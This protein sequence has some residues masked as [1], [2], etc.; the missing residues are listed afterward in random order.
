M[1]RNRVTAYDYDNIELT[2]YS[3]IFIVSKVSNNKTLYGIINSDGE[4]I[5]PVEYEDIK[6]SDDYFVLKRKNNEFYLEKR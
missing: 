5:I 6:I 4:E 3:N 2:D 1:D